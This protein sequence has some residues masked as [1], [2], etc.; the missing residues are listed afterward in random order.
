MY[1]SE[2]SLKKEKTSSHNE[3]MTN[4]IHVKECQYHRIINLMSHTLKVFLK[5]FIEEYTEQTISE[6]TWDTGIKSGQE[7]LCSSTTLM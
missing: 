4:K 6:H 5:I 2:I 1:T 7:Q 3:W